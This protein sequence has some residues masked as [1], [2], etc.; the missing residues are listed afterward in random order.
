[1]QTYENQN[2]LPQLPVPT[3]EDSV[4]LYLNC[5]KPLVSQEKYQK[6]AALAQNFIENEGYLVYKL[7]WHIYANFCE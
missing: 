3:L 4:A 1:M 7:P 2:K 5:L 6:T